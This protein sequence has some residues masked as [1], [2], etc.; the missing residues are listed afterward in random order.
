MTTH[1]IA[2]TCESYASYATLARVARWNDSF[3]GHYTNPAEHALKTLQEAV[4]LALHS[5]A[6][7]DE[8]S[9]V[10]YQECCSQM[11][12]PDWKP[13]YDKAKVQEEIADVCICVEKHRTFEKMDLNDVVDR[14]IDV[15]FE[16][17]WDVTPGGV[18]VR[19]GRRIL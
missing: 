5:G 6:K 15:L 4:E 8:I 13:G 2:N 1:Y 12:K 10:V 19:Q 11:A 16:R 17:S 3:G 9:E 7:S 18:L 14:K